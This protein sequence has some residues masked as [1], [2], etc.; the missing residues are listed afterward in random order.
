M[1]YPRTSF[2]GGGCSSAKGI[3]LLN[4][5]EE[6]R[7]PGRGAVALALLLVLT[8]AQPGF[9]LELGEWVRGLRVIPFLSERVDYETNIFQTPSHA[10]DDV[11]F[12]TIPGVLAE[13]SAGSYSLSAA[14]RAEILNFLTL[15]DL[16]R[17]HH[18]FAGLL[19]MEFNRLTV[20]VRD[21]FINTSDPA[22]SCFGTFPNTCQQP[23]NTE[24]TGRIES[25][26][27]TLLSTAEYR[28]TDRFSV[29]LNGAWAH[30]SYPTLSQLD[31]EEYLAGASVFWR[32]LPKADLSL[33]YYY[34]QKFWDSTFAFRDVTRNLILVGVRGDVT[35]K[36]SST[37]RFGFEN[38]EPKGTGLP[39]YRGLVASGDWSYRPTERLM[40]TLVTD[41]SVQ[42]STFGHQV[43]YVATTGTITATH[44]FGS[45]LAASL[46]FSA[47]DNTYPGKEIVNGQTKWRQ[48]TFLGWGGGIGYDVQWW[49]RVGADYVHTSRSSNFRVFNYQDDKVTIFA[50]LQI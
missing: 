34:G 2:T 9:A 29:G 16:D 47:G 31:R 42:E 32:V 10:K 38:R 41:R 24:L 5:I 11:I 6:G 4:R 21:D 36:L 40:L 39:S 37:F 26:T 8:T 1:G 49:L 48:D 13:W 30:V 33:N 18:I 23:A 43:F 27:N 15:S 17:V 3:G 35:P 50:T 12:R 20:N 44:K 7:R 22:G 14:Y 19:R 25:T 28:L 46:Q 45:K